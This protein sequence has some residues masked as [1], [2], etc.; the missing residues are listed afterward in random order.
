MRE[1]AELARFDYTTSTARN[2]LILTMDT[3][4]SDPKAQTAGPANRMRR[5]CLFCEIAHSE[6]HLLLEHDRPIIEATDFFVVAAMGQFIGGYVLICP[7]LHFL[8]LGVMHSDLHDQFLHL[9]GQVCTVLLEEYGNKIMLFEHG[10]AS[11]QMR[12]GS[13]LDHAHLHA[14]PVDLNTPPDWVS[15]CL[16]GGRI[17]DISDLFEYAAAG[18]P[19][20]FL[21]SS[22]STMYLYD[23]SSLPCQ[24]GRQVV[25][26]L[27]GIPEQWDWRM[28]PHLDRMVETRSRLTARL[29]GS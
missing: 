16:D 18:R 27:L 15:A 9:K 8:N 13:C 12:G 14:L 28:Y 29:A 2:G 21:E 7:R 23:A 24:Y 1:V 10:P 5:D 17:H 26:R 25:A 11:R 6:P 4:V 22:D 3:T 19:Y 20:F